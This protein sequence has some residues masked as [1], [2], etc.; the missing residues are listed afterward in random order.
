MTSKKKE[1]T[2]FI[3]FYFFTAVVSVNLQSMLIFL[4]LYINIKKKLKAQKVET[5]IIYCLFAIVNNST[6]TTDREFAGHT[7]FSMFSKDFG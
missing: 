1:P 5:T 6:W 3:L 7:I 4:V 2:W